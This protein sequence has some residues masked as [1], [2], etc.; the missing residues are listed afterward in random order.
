MAVV[1]RGGREVLVFG[2][3][4]CEGRRGA[5]RVQRGVFGADAQEAHC[6]LRCRCSYPPSPAGVGER[7]LLQL[8]L[9]LLL[10]AG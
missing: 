3:D 1:V 6:P 9:L 5:G 8:L 7:A 4:G 10:L 2:V